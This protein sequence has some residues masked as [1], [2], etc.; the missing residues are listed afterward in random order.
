MN[1][2]QFALICIAYY[3]WGTF[4]RTMSSFETLLVTII[5]CIV[6]CWVYK[7]LGSKL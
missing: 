3:L 5:L 1:F 7:K 4:S 2:L 6:N